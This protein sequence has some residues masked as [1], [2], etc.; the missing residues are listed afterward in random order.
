[1]IFKLVYTL[2]YK[3]GNQ[4]IFVLPRYIFYCIRKIYIYLMLTAICVIIFTKLRM[5]L[6][7]NIALEKKVLVPFL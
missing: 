1:M 4:N 2:L 3:Y 7:F 5:L 6:N